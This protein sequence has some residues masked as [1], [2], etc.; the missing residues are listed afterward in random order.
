MDGVNLERVDLSGANFKNARIR[1]GKLDRIKADGA[2]FS[3][4]DFT[5]V[6]L[7]SADLSNA[8]LT[9][10][11]FDGALLRRTRLVG[12]DLTGAYNLDPN[13]ILGACGDE[14][15]KLPRGIELIECSY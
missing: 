8:N 13:R 10:V 2:D 14:N 15:T 11:D 9:N 3:G 7:V 4:A 12:A 5:G 6:R 1:Q